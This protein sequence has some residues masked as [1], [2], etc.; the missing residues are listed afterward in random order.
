MDVPIAELRDHLT[1]WLDRVRNGAEVVIS[2]CGTPIA[3]LLGVSAPSTLQRLAADG[4]IGQERP[5]Q[6]PAAE[7]SRPRARR[8][9]SGFVSGERE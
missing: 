7:R 1:E 3:R 5:T 6:R 2:D 9:V 8:P 4:V